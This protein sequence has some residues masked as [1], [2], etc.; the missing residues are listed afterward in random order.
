M[1]TP[2]PLKIDQQMLTAGLTYSKCPA[3]SQNVCD[4][5]QA[6]WKIYGDAGR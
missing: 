2:C 1:S 6:E 5:E 3:D 4:R